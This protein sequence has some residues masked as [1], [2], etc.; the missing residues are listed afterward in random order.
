MNTKKIVLVLLITLLL[1]NI[2]FLPH[3]YATIDEIFKSGDDFLDASDDSEN[4]IDPGKLKSTSTTIYKM[5]LSIAICVSVLVG[6]VLGIQFMLGSVEGKV[7]VQEALV[8]YIIGCFIV[9][10]A[11]TIWSIV[12][13]IGN[14]VS[15][16]KKS[17]EQVFLENAR[18]NEKIEKGEINLMEISEDELKKVYGTHHIYET[19][20]QK[21]KGDQLGRG[22]GYTVEEAVGEL[23]EIARKIWQAC[24]DR[25]LLKEDGFTLK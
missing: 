19:L 3:S 21:I 16:A 1:I 12:I 6:A 14:N 15:G 4:I 9:F 5:L 18:R 17:N 13:N 7:K 10:G 8:P 23:G 24:K 22:G 11:F 20:K 2:V 25:G